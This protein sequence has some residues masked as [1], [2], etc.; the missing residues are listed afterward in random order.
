LYI[1]TIYFFR[2]VRPAASK[3]DWLLGDSVSSKGWTPLHLAASN[4][5]AGCVEYLAGER[6][7]AGVRVDVC[8]RFF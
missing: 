6:A 3:A 5:N 8:A 7:K 1:L 2:L 4:G